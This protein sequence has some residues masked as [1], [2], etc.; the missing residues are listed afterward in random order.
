MAW[1]NFENLHGWV[2]STLVDTWTQSA[3]RAA[4][5]VD[6]AAAKDPMTAI[7]IPNNNLNLKNKII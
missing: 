2:E 3:S 5:T 1:D 6:P 7:I 4:R